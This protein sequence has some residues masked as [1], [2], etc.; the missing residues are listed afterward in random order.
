MSV[1]RTSLEL[2]RLKKILNAL[3][4]KE[5][6][7]TE[8]ISLYIPPGKQISEVMNMLREEY[9]TAS[10]IKSTTTRKNVQDAIVR[11]QQRLKLFKETPETGL[12]IFCG[13]IPQNGAGSERIETYVIIPPEPINIYLYRCDSRFHTEHLQELLKEKEAYGILLI[14]SSEATIAIL[15]G[16]RLEIVSELT[17]GVPG[18]TRAG[19]Q[20]ARRYERLR[21]MR[22][23]EYFR[24]VGE[25]ANEVFLQKENLKGI[26]IGGPGPT[27]HDFA[28][29][30]YLN[31][32]LKEKILD[33][34]DTAYVDEQGVKE[35]VEKAPE[36]MKKVRYI[37]ERRIMQQFLYE[38]GHDTGMATYGEEAVRKALEA[39]V[40]K[41]LLLSEG[42]DIAR[43]KVKCSACGYEEEHT[44]RGSMLMSFEQ[45]LIGKPCPRCKAPSLS[46]A[47]KQELIENFAQLAEYANAEVEIISTE[48]EEGHM[49]KNAFGGIAAILRFKM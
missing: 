7:G 38:I 39:G 33:V 26:I 28:K 49:L 8:L 29:G 42:L 45:G 6:R 21:E 11:V 3:A 19:G 18:K 16:R 34:V 14:D 25:H 36:I 48:T 30:D 27:K 47:D 22:L 1:K 44:V 2:F 4:S 17:S 23:Q 12:V 32:Q 24:R 46:V 20:S 43:V 13:A 10:N 31:Y 15:E 37:E 5:G 35:V 40:V 41:T 9:G